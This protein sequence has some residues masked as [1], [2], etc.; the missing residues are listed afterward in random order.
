MSQGA[1]VDVDV[2]VPC[3]SSESVVEN[4]GNDT[5]DDASGATERMLVV[6]VNASEYAAKPADAASVDTIVRWILILLFVCSLQLH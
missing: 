1:D 3:C 2:D 5:N 6:V 4:N